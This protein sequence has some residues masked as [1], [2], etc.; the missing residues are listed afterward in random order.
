MNALPESTKLRRGSWGKKIQGMQRADI[1]ATI[2][3][4]P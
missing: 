1:K 3:V 4:L 2:R